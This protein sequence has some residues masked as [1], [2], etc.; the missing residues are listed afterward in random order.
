ME[1]AGLELDT[2][3]RLDQGIFIQ[4]ILGD[5]EARASASTITFGGFVEA[6][7]YDDRGIDRNLEF[8]CRKLRGTIL[9]PEEHMWDDGY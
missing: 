6:E 3:A 4:K 9:S 2:I 7:R 8:I 5:I 1:I